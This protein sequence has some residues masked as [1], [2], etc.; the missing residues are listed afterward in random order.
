MDKTLFLLLRCLA[1]AWLCAGSPGVRAQATEPTAASGTDPWLAEAQR[2]AAA[3]LTAQFAAQAATTG[4]PRTEVKLGRLDRRLRLN[5]CERVVAYLP[6]GVRLWGQT[7]VGLRCVK[8]DTPWNIYVPLT[9]NVYGPAL[10]STASLPA[11][12]VL[13]AGDFRQA[14]VN[15][16]EDRL[17][18]PVTDAT[19]LLG[20][21]LARPLEAGQPVR[22]ASLKARQWFTAG[23]KVHIR[24]AGNGFAVAGAGEAVTAGMEGQ[25]AR[26]RTDNG[27]VVSGMPVA[28]RLLEIAL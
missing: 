23:D 16:A 10:V 22:E 3:Q 9:V 19:L 12:H 8:G 1:L 4:Q 28:E 5:A 21:S 15:L 24:V 11:G 14:E 20:R 18:P 17:H 7:R 27:R 25:P 13:G 26:V 2:F 6:R